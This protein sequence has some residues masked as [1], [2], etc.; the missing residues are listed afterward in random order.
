MANKRYTSIKNDFCLTL[1]NETEIQE[2]PE[3]IKITNSGFAFTK[4]E[5]LKELPQNSTV[6]VIGVIFEISPL[7]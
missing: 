1:G 3:D 7:S 2:C 5:G 6:D 4:I